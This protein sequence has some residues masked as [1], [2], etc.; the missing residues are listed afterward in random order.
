ME[1]G[2]QGLHCLDPGEAEYSP[3]LQALQSLEED[4]PLNLE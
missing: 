1:P 3:G 2:G 4:K